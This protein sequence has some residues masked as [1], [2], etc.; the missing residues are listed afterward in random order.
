M[1]VAHP[2]PPLRPWLLLP[3]LLISPLLLACSAPDDDEAPTADQAWAAPPMDA[4][5]PDVEAAAARFEGAIQPIL[6]AYCARCHTT[7][8]AGGV[9][10][11]EVYEANLQPAEA[12]PDQTVAECSLTM[13]LDGRMP[14]ERGCTGDPVADATTPGCLG[15]AQIE[16]LRAWIEAGAPR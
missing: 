2:A 7:Q 11:A 12:C 10:L 6:R 13:I 4:S 9:N 8:G 15:D 1:R 5:A 16:A 3:C 14:P